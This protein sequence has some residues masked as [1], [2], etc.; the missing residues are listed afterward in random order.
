MNKTLFME[1]MDAI[2]ATFG[3]PVPT[4]RILDVIFSRV[5]PLPD[6]FMDYARNRVKN[7][8]SLPANFGAFLKRDLWPDYLDKHPELRAREDA[9]CC[10]DCDRGNPCYFS[11]H[12]PYGGITCFRCACRDREKG[13]TRQQARARGYRDLIPPAENQALAHDW[14]EAS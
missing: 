9:S 5:E 13:W 14:P 3:K 2:H 10:P 4:S 1:N 7:M 12:D 11:M 6:D 8:D